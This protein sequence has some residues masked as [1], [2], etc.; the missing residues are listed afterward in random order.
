LLS[1]QIQHSLSAAAATVVAAVEAPMA[2]A[3]AAFM[4]VGVGAFTVVAAEAFTV[5]AVAAFTVGAVG[6]FTATAAFMV[7]ADIMAAGGL[8]VEEVITKAAAFVVGQGL[9]LMERAAVRMAGLKGA[10]AL[11]QAEVVRRIFVRQST[12][13]SGTRSATPATL[14][15]PGV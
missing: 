5:A 7:G 9:V 14:A 2:A 4:V 10:A 3:V 6:A 12:M 13:A 1:H 11:A 15:V 8:L